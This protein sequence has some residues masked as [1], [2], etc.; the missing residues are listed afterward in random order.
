MPVWVGM[1]TCPGEG[2]GV[3]YGCRW[4]DHDCGEKGAVRGSVSGDRGPLL[5]VRLQSRAAYTDKSSNRMDL[6]AAGS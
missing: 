2:G 3:Q 4:N 6:N 5:D 1:I